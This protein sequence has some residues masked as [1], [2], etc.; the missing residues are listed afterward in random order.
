MGLVSSLD[1]LDFYF[2]KS[3]LFHT[4]RLRKAHLG[5]INGLITILVNVGLSDADLREAN[6]QHAD[7]C[8]AHLYR[9]NLEDSHLIDADLKMPGLLKSNEPK[10]HPLKA[11]SC[12]MAQNIPNDGTLLARCL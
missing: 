4:K 2:I 11:Q 9:S 3:F 6:L 1:D 12:L 5:S 7:L 8:E 10:W